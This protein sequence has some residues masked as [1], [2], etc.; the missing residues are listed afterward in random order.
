MI[1][2]ILMKSRSCRIHR[3]DPWVGKIPWR[4]TWQPTPVFMSEESVDRGAWKVH[5][6]TKSQIRLQLLDFIKIKNFC[7]AEDNI[8]KIRYC[9]D[10]ETYVQKTHLIK[11][12]YSNIKR[13][14]KTQQ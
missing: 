12:C 3:F 8:K 13:T 6:F 10:R 9:T 11:D 4:R 5:R 2:M 1:V 14:L 7:S